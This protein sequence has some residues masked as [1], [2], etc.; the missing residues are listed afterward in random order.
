VYFTKSI[1]LLFALL[2]VLVFA[3]PMYAQQE[4]TIRFLD[5]RSGKAIQKIDVLSILWDGSSFKAAA[6]DGRLVSRVSAK[7]DKNGVIRI[8]IPEP[9]PTHVS[10]SSLDTVNPVSVEIKLADILN[11]GVLI[12]HKREKSNLQL[13]ATAGQIIILTQKLGVAGKLALEIP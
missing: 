1:R 12:P 8:P 2:V 3:Q 5:F 6:Q 4:I 9:I 11:S 10:I 13:S 7:T